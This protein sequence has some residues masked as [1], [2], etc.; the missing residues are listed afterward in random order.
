M[1]KRFPGVSACW[2]RGAPQSWAPDGGNVMNPVAELL[3]FGG[4]MALG[5]FSPGPDMIL[6]TRSS[7]AGGGRV[8]AWT[9]IGIACGLMVHATLAIGGTAALL[10]RGGWLAECVRWLAVLYLAWLG[11]G[12]L[13]A[14]VAN[15]SALGGTFGRSFGPLA[16]FRRGFLCNLLNPKVAMFLAA[17]SAPFLAEGRAGWW[18]VAIWLMIVAE[19]L[20]LWIAWAWLLQW[21]P[22]RRLYQRAAR[23]IDGSFGVLLWLL[24]LRLVK[25]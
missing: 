14:A 6:L 23:W 4:V 15:K 11:W 2:V 12:L 16:A 9:A 10:A 21:R 8:G 3:I 17:V 1:S 18:P 13:K 5:Q 25:W 19:G 22:A 20:V 24:A 7:L